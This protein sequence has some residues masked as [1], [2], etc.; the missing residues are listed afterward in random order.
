MGS[1]PRHRTD[2]QVSA[3]RFYPLREAGDD[4]LEEGR[5][6]LIDPPGEYITNP[7]GTVV[8]LGR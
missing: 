4:F 8:L 1:E 6:I 2:R 5:E 3:G 7:R